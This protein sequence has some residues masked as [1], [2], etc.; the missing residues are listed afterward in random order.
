MTSETTRLP[1]P[2]LA[3]RRG[4]VEAGVA[5]HRR[6]RAERLGV[7]DARRPVGGRRNDRASAAGRLRP[8]RPRHRPR[9]CRDRHARARPPPRSFS[10]CASTSCLCA[11]EIKRAHARRLALGRA[12]AG[13]GQPLRQPVD[14]RPDMRFGHEDAPDRGAFLTRLGGH[15]AMRLLQEQVE[16]GAFRARRRG[17]GSWRSGCPVRRRSAPP[18]SKGW[19]WT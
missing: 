19:D 9:R 13:R 10:A 7:V 1:P 11:C 12:D 18:R 3:S 5:H 8:A 4:V 15:L 2:R 16:L 6:H 14:N 17:R